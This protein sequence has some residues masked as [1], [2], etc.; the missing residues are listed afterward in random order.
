ML[1]IFI[2][3]IVAVTPVKSWAQ[4]NNLGKSRCYKDEKDSSQEVF[5][6]TEI[7]PSYI[8]QS[9]LGTFLSQSINFFQL[10]AYPVGKFL[11]DTAVVKFIIDQKGMMSNLTVERTENEL[12]KNNLLRTFVQSACSWRAGS[13]S[14]RDVKSWVALKVFYTIERK[15]DNV[16]LNVGYSRTTVRDILNKK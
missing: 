13:F 15:S 1:K 7:A 9:G 2:I 5:T 16:S 10:N 3:F 12:F 8:G 14:S 11:S 6:K 4:L